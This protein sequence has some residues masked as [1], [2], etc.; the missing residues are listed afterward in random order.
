MS[1]IGALFLVVIGLMERWGGGGRGGYDV[2]HAV[3]L[4]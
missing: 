2:A 1:E 4:S 3:W